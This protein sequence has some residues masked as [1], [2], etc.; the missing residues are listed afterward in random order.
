LSA[1]LLEYIR[2]TKGVTVYVDGSK[3]DAPL[4]R[5][6]VKE[7]RKFVEKADNSDVCRL[8]DCRSGECEL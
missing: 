8:Q 5:L 2:D 7:A 6:N 1:L 3:K 4:Q